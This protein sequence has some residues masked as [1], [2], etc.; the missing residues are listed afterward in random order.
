LQSLSKC[1]L[2]LIVVLTATSVL[3]QI[4]ADRAAAGFH[5]NS[6]TFTELDF[7]HTIRNAKELK[8]SDKAALISAI[9]TLLRPF[10]TDL[11]IASERELRDIASRSRFKLV[12]LNG[13]GVPE[14]IVQPVGMKAGCGATGNCPLW[15]FSKKALVYEPIL[16][17]RDADGIG[18]VELHR[19]EPTLTNNFHDITVASHDSASEKTIF[20]YRRQKDWYQKISCYSASWI[21]PK[22]GHGPVLKEPLITPCQTIHPPDPRFGAQR[23]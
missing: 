15:V 12:D 19:V 4:S 1:A 20:V 13:D 9:S 6:Q 2:S 18:G 21:S 7:R 17:T 23:H 11:E 14:V 10:K 3:I 5:W 22:G 16:D 8:V